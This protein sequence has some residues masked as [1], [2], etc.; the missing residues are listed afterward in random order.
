MTSHARDALA[1]LMRL[2]RRYTERSRV[3][4]Y[5]CKIDR[6][7]SMKGCSKSM[8]F[9]TPVCSTVSPEVVSQSL[10][11]ES[12]RI[13]LPSKIFRFTR[14]DSFLCCDED[15]S[16]FAVDDAANAV[17]EANFTNYSSFTMCTITPSMSVGS[18]D[19]RDATDGAMIAASF[20]FEN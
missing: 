20:L 11:Y 7:L 13:V 8:V 4:P 1:A 9:G 6:I 16:A 10:L 14:T 19:I 5:V 15:V 2:M 3:G 17:E 18:S 12:E